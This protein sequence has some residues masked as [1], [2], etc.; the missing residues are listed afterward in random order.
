VKHI[1]F[2]QAIR[3]LY[4]TFPHP[5]SPRVVTVLQTSR[6]TMEVG[7]FWSRV[8]VHVDAPSRMF[9]LIPTDLCGPRDAALAAFENK[10]VRGL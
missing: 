9:T 3:A 6:S 2:T 4:Y 10:G 1:S 8:S 7:M 5:D